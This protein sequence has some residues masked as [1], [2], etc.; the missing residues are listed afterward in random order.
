MTETLEYLDKGLIKPITIAKEFDASS[1]AEAFKY[2]L[3][4]THIGRVGIR[5]RDVEGQPCLRNEVA[6]PP[7]K[8]QLDPEGSYL[9]VGGL[10]GLGR[11][12]STY[13]VEHGARNLIYLGRRA[14]QSDDQAFI[15][16]LKS[17]GVDVITVRGSITELD[18]VSR[19]VAEARTPLKGVLQL[20]AVQADENFARL[21]KEQWDYSL[22]PKVTGTWNLHH[23]TAGIKLDFFLLFSSM[24]SVIGLPGQANYASGNSF[25]DAFVQY[26]NNLG[27]ACSSVD[28]GP[29]ADVGFLS[30]R[31]ALLQTAILTGFKTL[32]GQEM[33]DSITLSMMA[34]V[35]D[36]SKR[37]STF[38]FDPNVFVLG[39][40]S[41]IPLSNPAN[42]AVWK[43][44][45]RMAIYHNNSGSTVDTAASS[46]QL[47]SYIANARADPAILK[48]SEA[49]SYFAHEIGK[50]LFG[51]LLKDDR[52]L[53]TS[54]AL[55]ELGLDSLVA[56]ELRAW[57]KQAFNF[58]ISVLE[59]LGMGNLE[60]L[61]GHVSERLLQI[62]AEESKKE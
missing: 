18:D 29:V 50:R 3:P 25:L 51:L 62:I 27:L 49:A 61:G 16:E 46:D 59:M 11:A 6:N 41:T 47:K 23:A 2:L 58:D 1:V 8:L 57:W 35:S 54:L 43:K 17:M 20:T 7:K 19:A 32:Q 13:M 9:L 14:G 5:I 56:I 38:Y 33:L 37:A 24:S 48:T 45:R 15:G 10:G 52:D 26:R 55:V 12:I 36:S 21:T 53:N 39:L 40:E 31:A 30:D 42:R 44:D 34:K 4:G 60:A 28:I 22:G